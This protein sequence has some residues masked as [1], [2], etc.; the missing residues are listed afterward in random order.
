MQH[1]ATLHLVTILDAVMGSAK[2]WGPNPRPYGLAPEA[3]ALCR[4]LGQIVMLPWQLNQEMNFDI[5]TT[6]KIAGSGQAPIAPPCVH[7]STEDV[8]G[9]AHA[10]PRNM[11]PHETGN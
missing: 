8:T 4:P 11:P 10:A 6:S 1:P 3:C 9:Q 5:G 2:L 7:V